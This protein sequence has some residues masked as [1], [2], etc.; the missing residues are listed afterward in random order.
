MIE[1]SREQSCPQTTCPALCCL[2]LW[3]T[4]TLNQ[5]IMETWSLSPDEP[6][7]LKLCFHLLFPETLFPGVPISSDISMNGMVS[8]SS[9]P[10]CSFKQGVL[11]RQLCYLS[12][13][14][15]RNQPE[16]AIQ[17]RSPPADFR[18]RHAGLRPHL[19]SHAART[20]VR[21]LSRGF[22]SSAPVRRD[23]YL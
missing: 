13:Q 21:N 7:L 5:N 2:V 9:L 16:G 4:A 20:E 11:R 1:S 10:G 12:L 8:W 15:S 19:P 22:L 18:S 17:P 23:S 3:D 6:R 14:Q